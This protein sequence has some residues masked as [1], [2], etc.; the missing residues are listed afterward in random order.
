MT[1][2]ETL[3][4]IKPAIKSEEL[5]YTSILHF[6]CSNHGFYGLLDFTDYEYSII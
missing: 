4:I 3:S 1:F 5:D 2:K 6:S